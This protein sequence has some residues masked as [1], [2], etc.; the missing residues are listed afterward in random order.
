MVPIFSGLFKFFYLQEGLYNQER[1]RF[2]GIIMGKITIHS[3]S[4]PQLLN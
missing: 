2:S 3:G 4:I 1:K